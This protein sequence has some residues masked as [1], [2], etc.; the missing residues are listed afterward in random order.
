MNATMTEELIKALSR[1]FAGEAVRQKRGQ[2]N[3]MMDYVSHG[4]V[5]K[6]LNDVYP[7][8]HA[9]M[10]EK[11]IV[12]DGDKLHCLGGVMRMTIG[13]VTREEAGGPTRQGTLAD[14][15]KNTYSDCLKRCA[16]RFGVALDMWE[17]A[18][19][20]DE[21][22]DDYA[23]S[24]APY[25][26]DG[27]GFAPFTPNRPAQPAQ[28][29]RSN[30]SAPTRTPQPPT[31]QR[32]PQTAT[33]NGNGQTHAYRDIPPQPP[34]APQKAVAAELAARATD[35]WTTIWTEARAQGIKDRQALEEFM[36]VTKGGGLPDPAVILARLR[37]E[38]IPNEA[39]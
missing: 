12:G 24:Q 2:G 38:P 19:E 1:P 14:D 35:P 22:A 39:H 9:E 34:Y 7:G 15:L 13:G 17:S 16:M 32:T 28:Q 30:G 18:E 33:A 6:R 36:G 37:D 21:D 8:W 11:W 31:P 29:A 25:Q 10:V 3:R 4:M 20:N 27:G 5:T 23:G 26:K